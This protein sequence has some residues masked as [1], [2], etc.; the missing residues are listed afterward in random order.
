[1]PG[2]IE[3]A[4]RIDTFTVL[5]ITRIPIGGTVNPFTLVLSVDQFKSVKK[6][7]DRLVSFLID[8]AVLYYVS[9]CML[10]YGAY[11]MMHSPWLPG[12]DLVRYC[13][14]YGIF[15]TYVIVLTGLCLLV[16]RRL[17]LPEDGLV[18]AGMSLLLILD[19]TFFNN[20]FYTIS[21]H[22]GLGLAVNSFCFALGMGLYAATVKIGGVPWTRRSAA[23]TTLAAVF[24]YY[25]PAGFNAGWQDATVERY[26]SLLCWTPLVVATICERFKFEEAPADQ[27]QEAQSSGQAAIPERMRRR[28]LVAGILIVFYIILSHLIAANYTYTLLF[29][30]EYLTPVFLAAGLL[31]FKLSPGL[32]FSGQCRPLLWMGAALAAYCS[33]PATNSLTINLPLGI[34]LSP[35]RYGFVA[36]AVY[37]LYFWRAYRQRS[38]VVAATLCL[39]LALSGP[40][41]QNAA[42]NIFH[43]HF[44]PFAFLTVL[45]IGLSVLKGTPVF[46]TL[47]GGCLLISI[48]ALT[49]LQ[50]D[51][52][53]ILFL[54]AWA[55][56]IGF[57]Q[58]RYHQYARQWIYSVLGGFVFALAAVMCLNG[59][60]RWAWR[61]DYVIVIIG[62]FCAGRFLKNV[63]LWILSLLGTLAAPLYLARNQLAFLAGEFRGIASPGLLA[64]ML[65]FLMLPLAYFLSVFKKRR[66]G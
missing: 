28:F 15:L 17:S 20:V 41:L 44:T 13:E 54:Q 34:A 61:S 22:V 6:F 46:P 2:R 47:A 50:D 5:S 53:L 35:F 42:F 25:Y 7:V 14:T 60:P 57:I 43:F 4:A 18:M 51:H 56:W 39:L 9:C 23:V 58:W 33:L 26:F 52:K 32:G 31:F 3:S 21:P 30:E 49:P 66:Q 27:R 62:L 10:L 24:V 29:H 65:A 38:W 48:L 63:V 8:T 16:L 37:L 40:S 55:V 64:T 59:A 1:V 11:S 19:P 36:V 12:S 45:F